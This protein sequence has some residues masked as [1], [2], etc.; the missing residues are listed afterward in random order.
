MAAVGVSLT[1]LSGAAFATGIAGEIALGS[2]YGVRPS[3]RV[4]HE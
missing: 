3:R 2:S 4:F 1:N